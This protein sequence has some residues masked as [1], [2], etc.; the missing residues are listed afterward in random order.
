MPKCTLSFRVAR[1]PENE[2]KGANYFAPHTRATHVRDTSLRPGSLRCITS[3]L[4]EK[5]WRSSFIMMQSRK[6]T[7]TEKKFAFCFTTVLHRHVIFGYLKH[8]K[9]HENW[10]VA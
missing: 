2:L 8:S 7:R 5:V 6:A 10:A 9:I 3:S 4:I 1:S